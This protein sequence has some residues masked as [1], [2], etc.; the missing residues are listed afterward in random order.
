MYPSVR[1]RVALPLVGAAVLIGM[2]AMV[3]VSGAFIRPKAATPFQTPLVVAYDQ[4][5]GGAMTHNP[6]NLAGSSCPEVKSSTIITHGDPTLNSQVVNFQGNVKLV[7]SGCPGA[8]DV[9]FPSATAA[10]TGLVTAATSGQNY[11]QDVRC[12]PGNGACAAGTAAGWTG[13]GT[14][15]DY[16]GILLA[17]SSIRITDNNNGPAGGPYVTSGTVNQITFSVP[18][19][20]TSTAATGVGSFC[21][22]LAFDASV[23]GPAGGVTGANSICGCVASGKRSNIENG[24]IEV[25]DGGPNGNPFN[26]TDGPNTTMARQGVFIP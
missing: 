20:C 5:V 10:G 26:T 13:A 6:A 23:G 17:S 21:T 18:T 2:L 3:P 11:M 12:G 25:F 16:V 9:L 22:P 1:K 14:G 8:C 19:K 4:C 24:Q 7:V 15:D